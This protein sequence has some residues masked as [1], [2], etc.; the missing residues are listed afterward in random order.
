[1][2]IRKRGKH[3]LTPLYPSDESLLFNKWARTGKAVTAMKSE[4]VNKKMQWMFFTVFNT[5]FHLSSLYL[6]KT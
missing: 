5:L 4:T 2:E 3:R 6:T 1:M